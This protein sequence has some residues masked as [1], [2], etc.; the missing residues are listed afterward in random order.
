MNDQD[1]GSC[2]EAVRIQTL[3][4]HA[5]A[6][7]ERLESLPEPHDLALRRSRQERV[8]ALR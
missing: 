5:R 4:R 8:G 2:A 1:L 7:L 6:L 3:M